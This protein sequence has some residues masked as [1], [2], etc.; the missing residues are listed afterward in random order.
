MC[1]ILISSSVIC[2]L[3]IYSYR[4]LNQLHEQHARRIPVS[5]FYK[6]NTCTKWNFSFQVNF[7]EDEPSTD[8]RNIL[9][10]RSI[11]MKMN[12]GKC[13]LNGIKCKIILKIDEWISFE[14]TRLHLLAL[15]KSNNSLFFNIL[16]IYTL[17][18][19]MV[20]SSLKENNTLFMFNLGQ[21]LRR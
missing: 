2:V 20:Y 12:T 21:M 15:C 19:V 11:W 3:Q 1:N 16:Y 9:L 4:R 8:V 17:N 7:L 5:A 13:L 10:V 14:R 6:S 18:L